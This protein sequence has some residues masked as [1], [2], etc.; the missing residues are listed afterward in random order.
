MKKSK[1]CVSC[2]ENIH[3]KRLEILPT[4]TRCVQCSTTNKKAGITVTKGTGDHT[5]NETIIV[6][7]ETF[8]KF[9]EE[10]AR[11]N[12]TTF[13]EVPT[14]DNVAPQIFLDE[15]DDASALDFSNI[16]E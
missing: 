4:A 10:E 1:K 13:D 5:Y 14:E 2:G 3:P 11:L 9:K 16:G 7:H 15:E 8:V 6:D 12:N